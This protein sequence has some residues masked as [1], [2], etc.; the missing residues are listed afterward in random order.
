MFKEALCV[1][2]KPK[3]LTGLQNMNNG[4]DSTGIKKIEK[5]LTEQN[6]DNASYK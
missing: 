3:E 4:R 5:L 1:L 6:L 2:R